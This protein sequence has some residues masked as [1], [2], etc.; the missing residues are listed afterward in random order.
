MKPRDGVNAGKRAFK[1]AAVTGAVRSCCVGFGHG[2]E[3][4][5]FVGKVLEVRA[6]AATRQ[7]PPGYKSLD[8]KKIV[9]FNK[10][11][12]KAERCCHARG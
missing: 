7:R 3:F 4:N 12:I 5:E 10:S 11:F 1:A 6:F 8:F 2:Q 9:P